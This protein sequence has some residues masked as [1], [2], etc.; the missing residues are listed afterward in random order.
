M[1]SN[2]VELW[3]QPTSIVVPPTAKTPKAIAAFA[4]QLSTREKNQLVAAANRGE[5]EMAAS[6]L[7]SKAMSALKRQ[8][9]TLGSEFLGEL[10]DRPDISGAA[11]IQNAI[12][13]YDALTLAEELGMFNA[14]EGMYLRHGLELVVHFA[15]TSTEEE[16]AMVMNPEDFTQI[17]RA[18]VRSVLGHE[19]LDS[20]VAFSRFRKELE[21]QV[22]KEDDT[23]IVQLRASSYFFQRTTLRVL[24]AVIKTENGAQ[25]ENALANFQLLLPLLWLHTASPERWHIGRAYAEVH[26]AGQRVA[27]S[28]LGQAL[29]SVKGFDYV[30][31]DLRSRVFI[32]AAKQ[33]KEAHFAGGNYYNEPGAVARLASL[34][35]SIPMPAVSDCVSAL[36]CIR[37]GNSYGECWAAQT[38]AK[39]L[40]DALRSESWRYYVDDCLPYDNTILQKL[41]QGGRMAK[42]WFN[43]S[44]DHKLTT[45]PLRKQLTRKLLEASSSRDELALGA[46]ATSLLKRL[47]D[48][49]S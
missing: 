41:A 2:D 3:H 13:D 15:S 7:W 37:L 39:Q 33:L 23:S 49:R 5:F 46:T 9:A 4:R 36:L 17:L 30:P 34:G 29:A 47:R 32:Q 8:L 25:L 10:L 1:A 11:Q 27:A 6:F 18:C 38:P 35:T 28:G 31:E 43:L 14:T 12:T 48:T 45:I 42:A 16:P 19:N 22:F 20:A 26:S 24:V 44:E 21:E 40:L